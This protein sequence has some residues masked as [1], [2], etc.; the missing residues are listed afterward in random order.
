[1]PLGDVDAGPSADSEWRV[2][3]VPSKLDR[4]FLQSWAEGM[5][6]LAEEPKPGMELNLCIFLRCGFSMAGELWAKE[7]ESEVGE[8]TLPVELWELYEEPVALG[9]W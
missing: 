3:L 1:M 6:L 7:D 4:W 8:L 9:V 2:Y 5:S